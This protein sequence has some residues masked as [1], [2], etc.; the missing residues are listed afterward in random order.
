VRINARF[1]SVIDRA[2]KVA[3]V[4]VD[5]DT[6]SAVAHFTEHVMSDPEAHPSFTKPAA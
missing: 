6:D 3:E 1:T 2:A 5:V 4:R